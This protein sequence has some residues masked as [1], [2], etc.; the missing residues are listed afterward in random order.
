MVGGDKTRPSMINFVA[1]E[2]ACIWRKSSIIQY[3]ESRSH[4]YQSDKEFVIPQ[5]IT[6]G[7]ALTKA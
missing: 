5:W 4:S 7:Q 3:L 1:A 2:V 6:I